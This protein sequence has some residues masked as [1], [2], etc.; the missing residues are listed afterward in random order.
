[1]SKWKE[2]AKADRAARKA[3]KNHE[4]VRKTDKHH[5]DQALGGAVAHGLVGAL[6][7][8]SVHYGKKQQ[9]SNDKAERERGRISEY[10]GKGGLIGQGLGAVAGLAYG[11]RQGQKVRKMLGANPINKAKMYGAN[12]AKGGLAGSM[13]GNA[14]GSLYGATRKDKQKKSMPKKASFGKDIRNHAIV[15]GIG[16]GVVGGLNAGAMA[17]G[18]KQQKSKDKS[19][20]QKGRISEYSGKG[21]LIGQGVGAAAGL[22]YSVSQN[23]G[24]KGPHKKKV[25][26]ANAADGGFAGSILGNLGGSMYG[27]MKKEKK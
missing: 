8:G 27:A 20:R 23:K 11:A 17:K 16:H 5:G 26:A 21:G 22:A 19:E 24:Y 3:Y 12:A 6:N 7:A 9:K 15:G 4:S 18:K 13:I 25:H 10:S 1:M 2:N 14:A